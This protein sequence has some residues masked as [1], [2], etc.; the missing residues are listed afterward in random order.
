MEL[1]VL[2]EK[3]L[4]AVYRRHLVPAFPPSELRPLHA[5]REM[6]RQGVY[7]PWGLADGEEIVGEAFVWA[8]AP[9]WGLLDYLCVAPERRGGGLGTALIAAVREAER[10]T[11]LF[12]EAEVPACAPDPDAARR[13]LD[14]YRRCGARQARYRAAVFGVPYHTL[15]WAEGAMDEA[16]L[17]AVH[18]E[19][20]RSRLGPAAW[21]RFI[22]IPW[23]ESMGMP[24]KHPWEE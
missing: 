11:V 20:Y 10:G 23:E 19:A 3:E 6:V 4:A 22:R 24:E 1:R 15:F 17:L 5:M 12:G 9:G 21:R 2:S 18:R 7:R 8:C 14:F 16:A 13:R